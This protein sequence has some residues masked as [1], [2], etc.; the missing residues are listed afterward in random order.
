MLIITRK[1]GEKIK[2]GDSIE[3]VLL[4]IKGRQASIGISA[5]K[6]VTILREE[7]LKRIKE[8]N[9][10]AAKEAPKTKDLDSLDI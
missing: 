2:I 6:G 10:R 9:I 1:I 3:I 5:P 7:V 8:E 4:D